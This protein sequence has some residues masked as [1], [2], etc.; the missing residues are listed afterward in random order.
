MGKTISMLRE[1]AGISRADLAERIEVREP[2]MER[3]ERGQVNADWATLRSLAKQFEL[4]LSALIELAE[5]C[6]PGE[7]G[8][9]WR[10]WSREAENGRDAD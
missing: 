10:R 3:I 1:R 5:E 8:E 7:G 9:Q 6:A 2:D 4:P